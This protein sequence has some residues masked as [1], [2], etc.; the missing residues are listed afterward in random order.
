MNKIANDVICVAA[1]PAAAAPRA[2]DSLARLGAIAAGTARARDWLEDCIA[3]IEATDGRV[4]GEEW[5][6][7]RPGA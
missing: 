5:A 2:D 7:P 3:R 1:A 6:E 4:I